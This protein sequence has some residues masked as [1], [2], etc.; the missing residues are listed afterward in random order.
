MRDP[1]EDAGI[2]WLVK[3]T[4]LLLL[5]AIG[6]VVLAIV[7]IV[8]DVDWLAIIGVILELPAT[9]LTTLAA[10]VISERRRGLENGGTGQ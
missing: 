8:M 2:Q 3:V 7:G 10:G 6:C 9:V 5:S 1:W 4:A